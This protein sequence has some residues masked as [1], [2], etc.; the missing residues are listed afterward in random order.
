MNIENIL[1]NDNNKLIFLK[2][3]LLGINYGRTDKSDYYIKVIEKE[4]QNITDKK[5][6]T[7]N[8]VTDKNENIILQLENQRNYTISLIQKLT[9][10]NYGFNYS[11]INLLRNNLVLL[12]KE[13]ER[14]KLLL[15]KNKSDIPVK[16]NSSLNIN[17]NL[18]KE[19][20]KTLGNLSSM[21]IN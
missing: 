20:Q 9:A 10:N 5:I 4:L 16:K 18:V 17:D 13:I 8:K 15:K 21:V 7:K 11:R 12:N 6:I 19:L 1:N 3:I 2:A 14:N